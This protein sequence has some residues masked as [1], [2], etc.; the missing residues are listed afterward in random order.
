MASDEFTPVTQAEATYYIPVRI[1]LTIGTP[2]V[3]TPQVGQ[4]TAARASDTAAPSAQRPPAAGEVERVTPTSALAVGQFSIGSLLESDFNWRAALSTALA[5]RLA[6]ENGEQVELTAKSN[7][8]FGSCTFVSIVDTECFVATSPT[9][10]LVAFRGTASVADWLADL[11]FLSITRPYGTVHRGFYYAF[12]DV[13]ARLRQILSPFAG[14][15]VVVTGHSLGGALATIAAAEWSG[16]VP[17]ARVYTYGQ[18]AVGTDG[19]VKFIDRNYSNRFYR[20]VNDN[21]AVARVPPGYQHVGRLFH[22]DRA[23]N[24]QGATESPSMGR[25]ETP[26]MSH[27]EFDQLRAELLA[28]RAANLRAGISAPLV[29]EVETESLFGFPSIRDHS[30]DQY[31][32]KIQRHV[33]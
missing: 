27:A 13:N 11:N 28:R 6:Y 1:A 32:P 31:I 30:L 5:S 21:D 12:Q 7:W 29:A 3:Q 25:A 33:R 22:F 23:G 24:L 26:T 8:G 20:L 18:P 2:T 9:V 10:A 19:F 14:L 17:V 15:P 4:A 16:Q